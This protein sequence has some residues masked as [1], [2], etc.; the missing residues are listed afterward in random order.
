M[1]VKT[2]ATGSALVTGKTA[3]RAAA[4]VTDTTAASAVA[5]TSDKAVASSR[6]KDKRSSNSAAQCALLGT[7]YSNSEDCVH[8]NDDCDGF[9][10]RLT[11][12][13]HSTIYVNP[14][15]TPAIILYLDA[16]LCTDFKN[17][18]SPLYCLSI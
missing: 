14:L 2:S 1:T 4:F 13:N 7:H 16:H 17:V 8:A 18:H 10:D 5:L 15:C 12:S 3:V 11:V 9:D 6:D